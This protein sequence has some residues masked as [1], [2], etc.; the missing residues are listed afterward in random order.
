[1]PDV[2]LNNTADYFDRPS[3]AQGSTGTWGGVR[4]VVRFCDGGH[5]RKLWDGTTWWRVPRL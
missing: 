3:V 1:V 5:Y 2:L 4:Y